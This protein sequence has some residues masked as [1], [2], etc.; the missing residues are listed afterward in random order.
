MKRDDS[1]GIG[2]TVA[3]DDPVDVADPLREAS[4]VPVEY[5]EP[6]TVS[7][8]LV[9][10]L[11]LLVAELLLVSNA[12]ID[13]LDVVVALMLTVPVELALLEESDVPETKGEVDTV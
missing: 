9:L 13:E 12:V 3:K 6:L 8:E 11:P 5:E 7:C 1:V 2:D 4:G 10:E